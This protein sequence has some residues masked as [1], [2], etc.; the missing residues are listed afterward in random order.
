MNATGV[1]ADQTKTAEGG[2]KAGTVSN[3]LSNPQQGDDRDRGGA[4]HGLGNTA[5]TAYEVIW[6]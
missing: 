3:A 1:E 2:D 4:I 5:T 6:V